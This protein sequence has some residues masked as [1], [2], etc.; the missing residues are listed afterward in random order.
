MAFQTQG[1]DISPVSSDITVV[2]SSRQK[3]FSK[4][5]NG[6]SIGKKI[7]CGYAPEYW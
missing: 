6:L 3:W 1:S 5:T 2:Q 4:I 7:K